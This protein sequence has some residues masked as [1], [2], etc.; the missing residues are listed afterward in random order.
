M[1]YFY[2]MDDIKNKSSV[3]INNINNLMTI[4]KFI[5]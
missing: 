4:K 2:I 1:I 3:I 5:P